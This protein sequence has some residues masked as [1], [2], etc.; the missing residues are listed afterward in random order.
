M[1]LKITNTVILTKLLLNMGVLE[2]PLS[3]MIKGT[4]LVEAWPDMSKPG[5]YNNKHL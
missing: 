1:N 4:D 5:F 3:S 2:T